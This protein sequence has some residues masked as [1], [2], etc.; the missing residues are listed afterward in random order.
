MSEIPQREETQALVEKNASAL[1]IAQAIKTPLGLVAVGLLGRALGPAGLGRLMYVLAIVGILRIFMDWGTSGVVIREVSQ[2]RTQAGSLLRKIM[3]LNGISALVVVAAGVFI[4]MHTVTDN[5]QWKLWVVGLAFGASDMLCDVLRSFF[6]GYEK[7]EIEALVLIIERV[8]FTG[9]A[10]ILLIAKGS[11]VGGAAC[12]LGASVVRAVASAFL[13]KKVVVAEARSPRSFYWLFKEAVPFALRRGF[14]VTL[15]KIPIIMLARFQVGH[16]VGLYGAAERLFDG[17]CFVPYAVAEAAYPSFSRA[18]TEEAADLDSQLSTAMTTS[19]GVA[20]AVATICFVMAEP[21]I[22]VVYGAEFAAAST[23]LSVV[24]WALPLLAVAWTCSSLL[25]AV[26]RQGT[27]AIVVGLSAAVQVAVCAAV[28]RQSWGGVGICFSWIATA[29]VMA[30][31][32]YWAVLKSV[33]Q[34]SVGKRLVRLAIS[35]AVLVGL[36]AAY[37]HLGFVPSLTLLVLSTAAYSYW[38]GLVTPESLRR[39][40]ATWRRSLWG[41]HLA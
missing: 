8:A 1:A 24:V 12:Y 2:H 16:V 21:A 20:V 28:A 30:L 18:K 29:T 6:R 15:G 7:M 26:N 36:G 14:G 13:V 27:A 41:E 5:T 33:P 4:V 32:A 9:F 31:A 19:V 25:Q 40:G 37:R 35:G 22:R 23:Y 34:L 3:T 10:V 11:V 17:A 38:N 39:L